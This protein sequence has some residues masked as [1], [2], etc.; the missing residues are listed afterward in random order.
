M[1]KTRIMVVE[2]ERTIALNLE[3]WLTKLGYEIS[4]SVTSGS[5]ALQEIERDTPDVV[6]M[7]VNIEGEIDG[8]ETAALIPDTHYLPVIYLT[9]YSEDATLQRARSTKP[10]GFL[11]KP[12]SERELHATIQMVLERRRADMLVRESE[13]RLEELVAQR[14]AELREQITER[15]KAED[16]L[17]QA[18]KMEAIGQLTGGIAHD[19]NNILQGILGSLDLLQ[20]SLK[21]GR[22]DEVDRFVGNA[23]ASANRAA[24]LTH[25]LLAFSRRQP[26]NPSVVDV[27]RL[28]RAMTDMVCQTVGESISVSVVLGESLWLTRCDANQLESAILNLVINARDAMPTGGRITIETKNIA[29]DGIMADQMALAPGQYVCLVV[30]DTGTGMPPDVTAQAFEPFFTTK[31]TGQGTGLGL[32]TIY[33]FARQSDGNVK[34]DSEVGGGTAIKVYLPRFEGTDPGTQAERPGETE[35]HVHDGEVILVIEDDP[36]VR[37]LIV[38]VLQDAGYHAL[39]AADGQAGLVILQSPQR[40]DLV[41]TDIGLPGLNGRQVADAGRALRPGLKVLFMTGYADSAAK[42]GGF[43]EPG[44]K[45]MAKPFVLDVLTAQIREMISA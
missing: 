19:F 24:G 1:S 7:D 37:S 34:I 30:S 28:V 9:A 40:V 2:D 27:N 23:I 41:I 21:L 45:L 18:Q 20:K 29:L 31:P 14:T 39:E 17:R 6:L 33:G 12:I 15:A 10:Y 11:L 5:Q 8:I 43:L 13:Q 16:A 25:R 42:A 35:P 26:L 22:S 3:R 36:L 44:M 38:D 32:S 4:S